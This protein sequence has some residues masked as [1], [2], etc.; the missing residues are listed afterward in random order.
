M[1]SVKLTKIPFAEAPLQEEQLSV[2]VR[3][4]RNGMP[5]PDNALNSVYDYTPLAATVA[6]IANGATRASHQAKR[7]AAL[8][9]ITTKLASELSRQN[10][11]HGKY[12]VI[13]SR[14]AERHAGASSISADGN[15][16]AA[17]RI[18]GD[19][20]RAAINHSHFQPHQKANETGNSVESLKWIIKLDNPG[21]PDEVNK[22]KTAACF[23]RPDFRND[24]NHIARRGL[25]RGDALELVIDEISGLV[26]DKLAEQDLPVT[27]ARFSLQRPALLKQA[28]V[29][30]G[31]TMAVGASD[32][33]VDGRASASSPACSDDPSS[34]KYRDFSTLP[35]V[36]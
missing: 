29:V 15:P 23:D 20:E 3:Y 4:Q 11:G 25:K 14:K 32:Q 34:R 18:A 35:Q 21:A 13:F 36:G 30:I 27:R 31:K 28:T 12:K 24:V 16:G 6:T 17:V 26:R 7:S 9:A 10:I 19:I 1:Y 2:K 5:T 22:E 33:P 8:E